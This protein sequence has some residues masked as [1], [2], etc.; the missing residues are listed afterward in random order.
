MEWRF[1]VNAVG[2]LQLSDYRS[3]CKHDNRNM[4]CFISYKWYFEVINEIETASGLDK[5]SDI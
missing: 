4:E 3:I 2:T 1:A 5:S